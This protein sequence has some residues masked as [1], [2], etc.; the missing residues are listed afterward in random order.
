VSYRLF[1]FFDLFG[2]VVMG[3]RL[4]ATRDIIDEAAEGAVKGPFYIIGEDAGG[5]LIELQ[6]VGDTLAALALPG[7]GLIGAVALGFVVLDIAFHPGLLPY[8]WRF[9]IS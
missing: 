5:Q 4:P 6:V 7:A 1:S 2:V 3:N 8:R 9:L